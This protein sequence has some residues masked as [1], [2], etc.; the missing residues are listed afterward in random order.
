MYFLRDNGYIRGKG[1]YFL[2]FKQEMDG[3]NLVDIVELTPIG[4]SCVELRGLPQ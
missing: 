1:D 4:Q 2:D 3:K